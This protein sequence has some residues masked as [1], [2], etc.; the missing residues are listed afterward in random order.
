MTESL[1][2]KV[3]DF[4][5]GRVLQ[6]SD[7]VSVCVCV[8]VRHLVPGFCAHYCLVCVV[9][10]AAGWCNTQYSRPIEV[11]G[12]RVTLQPGLLAFLRCLHAGSDSVG[13]VGG[14]RA[15]QG[16]RQCAGCSSGASCGVVCLLQGRGG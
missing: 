5:F 14:G 6:S 16:T 3:C 8:G 13:S 11:H 15:I 4:G 2:V 7:K 1:H 10:D 12:A 9:V